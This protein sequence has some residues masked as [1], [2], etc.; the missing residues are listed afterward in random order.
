MP[1]VPES[2]IQ[3]THLSQLRWGRSDLA[4]LTVHFPW[5]GPMRGQHD[6]TLRPHGAVVRVRHQQLAQHRR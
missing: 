5:H 1:G 4:L 6:N 2:A 3:H